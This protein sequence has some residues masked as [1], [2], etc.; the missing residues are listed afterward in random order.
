MDYLD[1]GKN[2]KSS[3]IH[4]VITFS[5]TIS[6]LLGLGQIPFAIALSK[7]GISLEDTSLSEVEIIE[8]L[9]KNNYLA[10][11]LFPFA[12]ALLALIFCIKYVHRRPILSLFSARA[13][14]DWKRFFFS[15]GIW[16]LIQVFLLALSIWSGADIRW[17]WHPESFLSLF[18]VAIF[19]VPLQ[20]TFEEALFRGY[21]LQGFSTLFKK[22]WLVIILSGMLFGLLHGAN[23]EVKKLGSLL[24]VYYVGSGIFLGIL[25]WK[26]QGLELS[27][28]YHA[29]NNIFGTLILTN[30]WQVFQTD[31]LFMDYTKPQLGWE[32]WITL[33]LIYPALLF[34][35]KRVYRWDKP[36]V[37]K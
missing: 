30:N 3:W 18:I 35:Y 10:Y 20:T 27:M 11:Q 5:L 13:N 6:T 15:F 16:G 21:F 36:S 25:A 17:N 37:P 12:L 14:F 1:A 22:K 19:I 7:V 23:P 31:A 9:G 32:I 34:L 4:Y 33:G 26:D 2:G 28:G 24:L 8:L 29:V